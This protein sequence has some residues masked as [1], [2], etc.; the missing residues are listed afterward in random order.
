[1]SI[2]LI[3]FLMFTASFALIIIGMAMVLLSLLQTRKQGTEEIREGER[4][5][6]GGAVIIIGPFPFAIGSRKIIKPLLIL[7][8]AFFIIVI[9]IFFLFLYLSR[10]VI[11]R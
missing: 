9:I 10:L 11:P 8:L 1:M 4:S 2:T 5:M 7:S 3:A 6:E